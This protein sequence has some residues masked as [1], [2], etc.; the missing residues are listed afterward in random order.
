MMIHLKKVGVPSH[1][2]EQG[3][4]EIEKSFQHSKSLRLKSTVKF[5]QKLWK[6]SIFIHRESKIATLLMVI[7]ELEIPLILTASDLQSFWNPRSSL[8]IRPRKPSNQKW[9]P[10]LRKYLK[11]SKAALKRPKDNFDKDLRKK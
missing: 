1:L 11:R 4:L 6:L 5:H 9:S 10:S 3:N 2:P 8:K 7:Q